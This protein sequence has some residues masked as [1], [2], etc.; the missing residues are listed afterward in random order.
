ML[1][2]SR[3]RLSLSPSQT[4][5]WNLPRKMTQRSHPSMTNSIKIT[6]KPTTVIYFQLIKQLLP[7]K[8]TWRGKHSKLCLSTRSSDLRNSPAQNP[9]W[10]N[11]LW[12]SSKRRDSTLVKYLRFPSCWANKC[13]R[14]QFPEQ[15]AELGTENHGLALQSDYY[16]NI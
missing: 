9:C 6:T 7:G 1:S 11:R 2:S 12:I 14:L 4:S 16:N 3:L 10:R 13:Q 5:C 8:S 15:T